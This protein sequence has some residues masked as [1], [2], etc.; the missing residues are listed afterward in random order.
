MDE[1]NNTAVFTVS[2]ITAK[3]KSL[4]DLNFPAVAIE[5]EIS[6]FRPNAGGHLYFTLKD[7][8][9]QLSAVMFKGRAAS[10]SFQ[11]R[12]GTKVR[13]F[14]NLTVY[15]AQ[16]KYQINITRM[17]IAGEGD[18]LRM[19]EERKRALAAEGLFDS[20]RKK[21]I[22]RLPE[23]V[24]IVTSPTGAAVRDIL[25]IA[26]RRNS[27]IGITILPAQVQGEAAAEAVAR[28]IMT[29]NAFGMC[30]VLI[31]GR[32]GG[33]LEDLLPFSD[34]KVVRAIAESKI[35][36]VSA[37]GHEID[38]SLA[39]Y[40]ADVRA[41][42]PSA[43]A[44]LVFTQKAEIE[45]EISGAKSIL[46]EKMS[47]LIREARMELRAFDA[48]SMEIRL[49]SIL[50]PL[51]A[52]LD[53]AS[54][55][56]AAKIRDAAK[57]ASARILSCRRTL[58]DASPESIMRRGYAVVRDGSGN[59]IRKASDAAPGCELSITLADGTISAVSK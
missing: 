26:R 41:P 29:A 8:G 14:G 28:Q 48:E 21:P 5:G 23:T 13:A 27:G 17:E 39:D 4:I 33:S 59:V 58:E 35:P 12:D 45:N 2:E 49:R 30:D 34:E 44:E 55:Q 38:W 1:N 24:G 11:P 56:A 3:V 54:E 42:T 15:A 57:D 25:N 16:G 37:V 19:I 40:A 50:S 20:A 22:P 18:I 36:V 32:G 9:A 31:V 51:K 53:A 43:A 47:S 7:E 6:N 46:E 52:R 10:L